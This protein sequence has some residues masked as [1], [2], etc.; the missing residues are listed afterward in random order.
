MPAI[1]ALIFIIEILFVV[2]AVKRDE[3]NWVFLIIFLPLI[4]CILYFIIVVA[5]EINYS[6]S[7]RNTTRAI[8]N[9]AS[10]KLKK[11]LKLIETN[12][13]I[14]EYLHVGEKLLKDGMM[15][16][17]IQ[18]YKKS[19]SEKH[20]GNP[21]LMLGLAKA[22]FKNQMYVEAR[23]TLD[24]LIRLNPEF[25]SLEGH[26]LYAR[27]LEELEE[28]T[29]AREEYEAIIEYSNDIEALC[30]FAVFL[31]KQG[32][33]NKARQMF[34]QLLSD[35]ELLSIDRKN[36]KRKWISVAKLE[37]LNW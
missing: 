1:G 23:E 22:Y 2:H 20:E 36:Q 11:R 16:D 14:V 25:R 29:K 24:K 3:W 13:N 5:P 6:N 17:A 34:E 21:N 27:T 26:L 19:L 35:A 28:Y 30:A 12:S 31:K 15:E 18:L 8:K 32:D 37:L 33:D 7:P 4:G 10:P 9:R